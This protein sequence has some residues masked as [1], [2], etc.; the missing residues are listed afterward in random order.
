MQCNKPFCRRDAHTLG[1]GGVWLGPA[2]LRRLAVANW[3]LNGK[4]RKVRILLI[5]FYV[6][7]WN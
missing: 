6:K 3:S 2:C 5:Q 7:M 1:V 4:K